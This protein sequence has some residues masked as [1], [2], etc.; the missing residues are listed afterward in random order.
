VRTRAKRAGS[1]PREFIHRRLG[2]TNQE[3]RSLKVLQKLF[4]SLLYPIMRAAVWAFRLLPPTAGYALCDVIAWL[5]YHVDV[6]RRRRGIR[7]FGIAFP[8]RSRAERA[9]SVRAV[10]RH[11]VR[12][13]Y[14]IIVMGKLLA[15]DGARTRVEWEG[16]EH[17]D[18]LQ[19][20]AEGAVYATAHV[21]NWEV[22]GVAMSA[23][24]N[25]L[26]S[27]A[28]GVETG[29]YDRFLRG[30]REV[31]GQRIVDFQGA[32]KEGGRLL[33]SGKN[34]AFVADQHAPVNR[35]WVPFFG[36]PAGMIKTPAGMARRYRVPMI[37][38]FCRRIGPGY[39][40]KAKLFPPIHPDL[41]RPAR[42][43][44]ARMTLAYVRHLEA[45]IRENPED[46]LW[47]HRIWRAPI[48]GEEFIGGDGT[49]VRH[50]AF[51]PDGDQADSDREP[52]EPRAPRPARKGDG[53]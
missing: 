10:Y 34:L 21:G 23:R 26:N 36:V 43:D 13:S 50:A 53:A 42:E 51:G 17:T 47:L 16:S 52:H 32:I 12:L 25:P 11:V 20:R 28:R 48:D 7:N 19:S 8:G 30:L 45:Y 22:M 18:R 1:G 40:F 4:F 37:V 31:H 33:T 15:G 35:I 49:H 9:A 41:D 2:L 46:Y 38:G 3:E 39:R 29:A 6:K 5:G 27:V 14:E 44:V 24:G